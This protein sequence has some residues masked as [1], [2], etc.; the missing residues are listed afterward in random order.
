VHTGRE[1]RSSGGISIDQLSLLEELIMKLNKILAGVAFAAA[2]ATAFAAVTFDPVTGT[3]FVG[4]GDVQLAFGWNNKQLQNNATGVT[5]AYENVTKY[6]ATCFA[7]NSAGKPIEKPVKT[8][9]KIAG[10]PNGDPRQVKGQN[11]FTG[12]ILSGF[13]GGEAD[14]EPLVAGTPCIA[15]NANSDNAPDG[16]LGSV[17]AETTG[18]GLTVTFDGETDTLTITPAP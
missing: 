13:D 17:T 7:E 2:A 4:K 15:I 18:E 5:F 9:M 16:L 1:C 14:G 12:F 6:S 10:D 11:Q 8:K 3:G